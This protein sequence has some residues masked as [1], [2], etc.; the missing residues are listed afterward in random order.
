M[1]KKNEYGYNIVT[2]DAVTESSFLIEN[3]SKVLGNVDSQLPDWNVTTDVS[4]LKKYLL[5]AAINY[6]NPNADSFINQLNNYKLKIKDKKSSAIIIVYMHKGTIRTVI[7]GKKDTVEYYEPITKLNYPSGRTFDAIG[8]TNY[9]TKETIYDI[10]EKIGANAPGTLQDVCIFSH[11]YWQ[12]PILANSK[13]TDPLDIDMRISDISP[14]VI[15][16]LQFKSAFT[17][18]GIFKIF[19]CQSHPPFN[20]LLKSVM[21]NPKYKKNGSTLDTEEFVVKDIRIPKP[22]GGVYDP[23][24]TFVDSSLFTDIGGGKIKFTFL[25]IKTIFSDQYCLS[26]AAKL[27]SEVDITVQYSLPA[28]YASFGSPEYFRI[29]KDTEMN[30]PFFNTYLGIRIGELN[31]GIYD[32]PTILRLTP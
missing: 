11:A 6:E 17:S 24:S 10:I 15:D 3:D 19:G 4:S 30:V 28:T 23:V 27:A 32:R 14:I 7:E 26:F 5:V 18:T 9:I 25:Q 21:Q 2:E 29:S 20:Y 8:K 13:I 22:H 16:Y 12:G 1:A 31:Y